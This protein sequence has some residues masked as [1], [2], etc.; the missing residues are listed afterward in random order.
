VSSTAH[1]PVAEYDLFASIYD[2]HMAVDFARRVLPVLEQLVLRALSPGAP[3]L[4]LCCGS[5]RV[6]QALVERGFR[7]TGVDASESM[8]LLARHCAPGA[9]FVLADMRRL[10]LAS[11]YAAVV[12][13]FNSL[14]HVHSVA[15]LS[16]VFVNA[17]DALVP[18]GVMVFDLSM[19]PQ[20]Q[21][22]WRG[23]FF[24]AGPEG[25]CLIRPSYHPQRRLARNQITIFA[26]PNNRSQ[27]RLETS[28]PVPEPKKLSFT[29]L[30][31]CHRESEVRHALASASFAS[32]ECFDAERDLGMTGESGRNFFRAIRPLS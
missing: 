5:G 21:H 17:H 10:A 20:Y 31:K 7:V 12:S 26:R 13:T 32:I 14:A 25:A 30:Q 6:T 11:A 1:Q 29:I 23:E 9:E 24:F 16:R 28:S 15:D 19:H 18:G 3:V 22:S 4:D 27:Q 8:L 2:R